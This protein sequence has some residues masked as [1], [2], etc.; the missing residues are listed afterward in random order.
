M[1]MRPRCWAVW[2]RRRVAWMWCPTG[3]MVALVVL[4]TSYTAAAQVTLTWDASVSMVDGYWLYY[5]PASGSY[6]ARLDVGA[7][8]TYTITGLASGQTY[9]FAVTAYDRTGNVESPFSNEVGL[10]L[11]STQPDSDSAQSGG[12]QFA[13]GGGGCTL[14]RRTGGDP[15]GLEM[16]GLWF[17]WLAAR[18]WTRGKGLDHRDRGRKYHYGIGVFMSTWISAW[19]NARL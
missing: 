1:R 15:L 14:H 10:T 5:G 9:Y 3:W 12:R 8:T 17:L 18:V 2:A 13:G 16:S 19:D 6:T 4:L 7:A 11:Q